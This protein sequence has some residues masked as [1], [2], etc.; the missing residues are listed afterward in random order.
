M[1]ELLIILSDNRYKL[2]QSGQTGIMF[3]LVIALCDVKR[4]YQIALYNQELRFDWFP[5]IQAEKNPVF[6]NISLTS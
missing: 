5:I 1:G 4:I 3:V 2:G 6:L